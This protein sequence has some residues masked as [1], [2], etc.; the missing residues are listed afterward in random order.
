MQEEKR[1]RH[2][3]MGGVALRASLL[4]ER[5]AA[6]QT[7]LGSTT[8]ECDLKRTDFTRAANMGLMKKRATPMDAPQ[9][10][11]LPSDA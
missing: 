6:Q 5:P 8:T 10:Q 2:V 3:W 11:D 4:R 7:D 9:K 1:T